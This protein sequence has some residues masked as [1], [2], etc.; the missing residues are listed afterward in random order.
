MTSTPPESKADTLSV[1]YLD[2]PKKTFAG[3]L[4]ILL[5]MSG[6]ALASSMYSPT[7]CWL[8]IF[9][10]MGYCVTYIGYA[11]TGLWRGAYISPL[12]RRVSLSQVQMIAWTVLIISA[13][14]SLCFMNLFELHSTPL[15]IDVPPSLWILMGISTA[16]T[17]T[18]PAI[19][20]RKLHEN[21]TRVAKHAD[22]R[23]AAW[24]DMFLSD[25]EGTGHAVDIAKMQMFLFTFILVLGYGGAIWN[26][27]EQGGP[28]EALPPVDDGINVLLGVSHSGYLAN[29]Q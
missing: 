13:L 9:G 3:F 10:F 21:P 8:V 4:L 25:I 12:T 24:S 19:T 7:L 15:S 16:S 26:L 14:L 18:S 27:L 20:D 1:P 11:V 6:A 22:P 2:R 23:L 17:V 29:K 5:A 28:I